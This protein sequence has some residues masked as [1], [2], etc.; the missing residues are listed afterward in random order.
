M[1]TTILESIYENTRHDFSYT[2]IVETNITEEIENI[3]KQQYSEL[4]SKDLEELRNLLFQVSD[5]SEMQGFV[6]GFHYAVALLTGR[7]G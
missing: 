7:E 3:L 4:P 6:L 2:K 1:K 5:I